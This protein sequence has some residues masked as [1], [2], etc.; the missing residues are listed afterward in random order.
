MAERWPR[1]ASSSAIE[2]VACVSFGEP[3]NATGISGDFGEALLSRNIPFHARTE[4]QD[5]GGHRQGGWRDSPERN[6]AS[7]LIAAHIWFETSRF[8]SPRKNREAWTRP[9]SHCSLLG[10]AGWGPGLDEKPC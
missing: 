2:I 1:P 7:N 6:S 8:F 4:P 5:G 10:I 3:S 9:N